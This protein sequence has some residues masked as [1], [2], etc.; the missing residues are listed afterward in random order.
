MTELSFL[1]ELLLHHELSNDTKS[2]IATRIKDVEIQITRPV[3]SNVPNT[4]VMQVN[5]AASHGKPVQAPSTLALMA[6]HGDIPSEE[7]PVMP[8]IP[9]VQP[10]THVAQTPAAQAALHSRNSAIST[11]ISGIPEKGATRPRKF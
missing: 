8:P 6:K 3:L 4:P 2:L 11:S 9:P 10:V 5:W 7:A 1:I